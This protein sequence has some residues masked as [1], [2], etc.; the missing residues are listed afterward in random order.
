MEHIVTCRGDGKDVVIF[1]DVQFLDVN[2]RIFPSLFESTH[3]K[4][5]VSGGVVFGIKNPPP[6]STDPSVNVSPEL[7]VDFFFKVR[8][9]PCL[10][11]H[12]FSPSN[13]NKFLKNTDLSQMV[14]KRA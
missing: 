3:A 4:K 1:V 11:L 14:V 6:R 8:Y 10:C 5:L 9:P 2:R 7:L 12:Q 13:R